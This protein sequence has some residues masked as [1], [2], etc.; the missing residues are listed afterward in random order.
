MFGA[1][2]RTRRWAGSVFYGW[3][4]LT[5]CFGLQILTS[6][7]TLQ[8]FG[9]Y[10]SVMQPEFG[11]SRTSFAV[12]FS[13]QQ[14]G[15]GILG[16]LQGWLIGRFG[17]RSI[18]RVGIVVFSIALMLFSRVNSLTAFYLVYVLISVGASFAG[19]LTL[20][21]VAAQWFERRRSTAFAL[22]QTGISASGLLVPLVAWSL[23]A[24]GW[25]ATAFFTGVV[26]LL[27]G[28]PLTFLVGNRPED[29][30]LAPDG[31]SPEPGEAAAKVK[32]DFTA[33]E[34]LRTRAFWLLSFGHATALMV[35]FAV[36]T[37]LVLHLEQD[38]G[39]PLQLAATMVALMTAMSVV[40]QLLG[41]FLG[42]A[43]NK[44]FLATGAMFG[45]AVGLLI[46]AFGQ[47][48]PWVIAFAVIHG[49]SWGVRGPLMQSIRADY[50][51][52]T[53]F[54]QILGFSNVI[55]TLGTISGPIL[56]GAFADRFGNYT[57]GFLVL[58]GLAALGSAFFVFAT[59]PRGPIGS[60]KPRA[61]G[62]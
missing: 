33:K 1:I 22:L 38:L 48:L 45:H 42:D 61:D 18:L 17:A 30:G 29:Y 49:L 40:G 24:N 44:R 31:A 57:L 5:A 46:L 32:R 43:L 2:A 37:H 21:A 53:S 20:N 7:F 41:G 14:A 4:V 50:F 12:A 25:R 8:S 28:I 15:S 6:N 55:V 26:V 54:A 52:R 11:W 58:A 16:P 62:V 59:P 36:L 60:L 9:A 23:V 51:G 27:L 39:F 34:A 10:I 56:A 3:W 35:V 19:F 47:T 13:I